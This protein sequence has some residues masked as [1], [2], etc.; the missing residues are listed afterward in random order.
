MKDIISN[1]RL[2]AIFKHKFLGGIEITEECLKMSFDNP[3]PTSM[4]IWHDGIIKEVSR[5][6]VYFEWVKK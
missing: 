3:D 6:L 5:C 2:S 1:K 4:F